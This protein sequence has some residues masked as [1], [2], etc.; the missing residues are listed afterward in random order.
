M[1]QVAKCLLLCGDPGLFLA[2]AERLPGPL[3][4]FGCGEEG[5]LH[6]YLWLCVLVKP[7]RELPRGQ[8]AEV[9]MGSPS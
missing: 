3:W 8:L 5:S 9:A 1:A 7:V 4:A 2:V 6:C